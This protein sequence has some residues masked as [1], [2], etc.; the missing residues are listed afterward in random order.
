MAELTP[1]LYQQ[2]RDL[3]RFKRDFTLDEIGRRAAIAA[4]IAGGMDPRAAQEYYLSQSPYRLTRSE[5]DSRLGQLME[6]AQLQARQEA[7]AL[8]GDQAAAKAVQSTQLKISESRNKVLGDIASQMAGKKGQA[9]VE[10][11]KVLFDEAGEIRQGKDTS[12]P[13]AVEV[14]LT[15]LNVQRPITAFGSDTKV[16]QEVQTNIRNLSGPTLERYLTKIAALKGTTPEALVKQMQEAGAGGSVWGTIASEYVDRKEI[17][18]TR[19]D[20]VNKK[21]KDAYAKF[22]IPVPAQQQLQGV[23]AAER[24]GRA[25][26]E[27]V[28]PL[29]ADVSLI[30][31]ALTEFP[32][33]GPPIR[34][35]RERLQR[36]PEFQ[37]FMEEYYGRSAEDRPFS[38]IEERMA[39]RGSRMLSRKQARGERRE[40]RQR[41]RA[42]R[43]GE[44]FLRDEDFE[45]VPETRPGAKSAQLAS[46]AAAEATTATGVGEQP[47]I[48]AYTTF[49]PKGDTHI[50]R[51]KDGINWEIAP[52]ETPTKFKKVKTMEMD[53]SGEPTFFPLLDT[54]YE[55][56][57][58]SQ[59]DGTLEQEGPSL[60]KETTETFFGSDVFEEVRAAAPK[61]KAP[62]PKVEAETG[63]LAVE[64]DE[65]EIAPIED[66]PERVTPRQRVFE[67]KR[68]AY[69]QVPAAADEMLRQQQVQE[70][71]LDPRTQFAGTLGED[72]EDQLELEADAQDAVD[73]TPGT[74]EDLVE[75]AAQVAK[76]QTEVF[77]TS[78]DNPMGTPLSEAP[79]TAN[80]VLKTNLESAGISEEVFGDGAGLEGESPPV[81]LKKKRKK[82][83]S[84]FEDKTLEIM[85]QRLLGTD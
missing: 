54:I 85:R 8:K 33:E 75:S 56:L 83:P 37:Q 68:G 26:G 48:N 39:L 30:Q 78:A 67:S 41:L 16:F 58:A 80:E 84:A 23:L 44:D 4:G 19:L 1:E 46:P 61:G 55:N 32:E 43:K 65:Q 20:D 3:S 59:A 40:G 71:L 81:R 35:E 42:L 29:A 82:Q 77:D 47:D 64:E 36:G 22:T 72:P 28:A 5:F 10:E 76:A 18:D 57:K 73:F 53:A 51:T 70:E 69:P 31:Q 66:I 6:L 52:K 60:D 24:T 74:E 79:P 13:E 25:S 38:D 45:D 11:L 34:M 12:I 50:Y 49:K 7:A 17:P 63:L 27:G 62:A 2:V 21:I 14:Q 9:I 15:G